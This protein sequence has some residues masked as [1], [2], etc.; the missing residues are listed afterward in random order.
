[1]V[2]CCFCILEL[3]ADSL[4]VLPGLLIIAL[5]LLFGAQLLMDRMLQLTDGILEVGDL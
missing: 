5:Y 1:M 2:K 4:E 3:K